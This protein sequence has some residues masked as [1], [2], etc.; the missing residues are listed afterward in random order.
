MTLNAHY[1]TQSLNELSSVTTTSLPQRQPRTH[2]SASFSNPIPSIQYNSKKMA[3]KE[4]VG[5]ST[6]T[7]HNDFVR[8]LYQMLLEEKYID[9]VRWTPPGT[10]FVVLNTNDF[11]KNI[12][13][14]H[15]KHSNFASFVRQLNKY[16][17]HKVKIPNEEK[18]AYE[19]GDDAWEFQ[20]PD[21]KRDDMEALENIRRKPPTKKEN[22]ADM[23]GQLSS[24]IL[25]LQFEV[26]RLQ[27][28]LKATT[29]SYRTIF[30]NVVACRTY[31]ERHYHSMGILLNCLTQAG[32]K[33]PPLDLP[34]PNMIGLMTPGTVPA[35]LPNGRTASIAMSGPNATSETRQAEPH[36]NNGGSIHNLPSNPAVVRQRLPSTHQL[37]TSSSGNLTNDPHQMSGTNLDHFMPS[38]SGNGMYDSI[39]TTNLPDPKFHV[40]LV[41]DDNVCI[42][43][44]RKHLIKYGCQVTVVT[45]GLLAIS[46]A[47]QTKYDLVL[48][49]IVMPNLDGASAANFIRKFDENT[50]IVAMTSNFEEK[51]LENYLHHGMNDI[52]AKPFTKDA[53]Y[54]ML[55]KHLLGAKPVFQE[56]PTVPELEG[57]LIENPG[58]VPIA[59]QQVTSLPNNSIITPTLLEPLEN[60]EPQQKKNRLS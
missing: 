53:L 32:I 57:M 49:D 52:L 40:L 11:T 51:D 56:L 47:K 7:G 23:K 18:K 20:H 5:S 37:P 38:I 21:F 19:Y 25:A 45:D 13:P 30:D 48:M 6:S 60:V 12:L 16:D 50:P 17:F 36:P 8:K 27:S 58:T 54:L 44:C 42:Q 41:E 46:T 3:S 33:I 14:I 22:P 15:F 24:Q 2:K 43:L 55:S 26:A 35:P 59:M 34:N 4:D 10:S 31:N 1:V 9:V 28:E 29:D 39:S